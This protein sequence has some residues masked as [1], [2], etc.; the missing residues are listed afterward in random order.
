[1]DQTTFR[2]ETLSARNYARRRNRMVTGFS[3]PSYTFRSCIKD[4][5]LLDTARVSALDVMYS[6]NL[7]TMGIAEPV[8]EC[9]P[10]ICDGRKPDIEKQNRTLE[11]CRNGSRRNDLIGDRLRKS[12]KI[13]TKLTAYWVETLIINRLGRG[14]QV[15]TMA[16]LLPAVIGRKACGHIPANRAPVKAPIFGL[17]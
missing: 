16:S 11:S 1:M 2:G 14:E 7:L 10:R 17:E 4:S 8:A 5:V 3:R 12:T 13:Q 15:E 9:Q 6:L